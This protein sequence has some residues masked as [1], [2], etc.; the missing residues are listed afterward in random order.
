MNWSPIS[1]FELHKLIKDQSEVLEQPEL[2]F[3]NSIKVSLELT[4][5]DRFGKIENVFVLAKFNDLVLFY[6]DI[7]EGFEITSL[8]SNGVISEYGANQYEL[9]HVIHQLMNR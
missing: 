3:Y 1:E 8:N 4:P 7:E 6:E 9:S 2:D 5:I